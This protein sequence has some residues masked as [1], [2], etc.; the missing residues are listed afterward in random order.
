MKMTDPLN[1]RLLSHRE[2]L[3]DMT[4]YPMP[5]R[6]LDEGE[7]RLRLDL[8]SLTTNNI[9]YAGFGNSI[10]YWGCF[11]SPDPDYG[12]IPV[13]GFADIVEST[14]ED[15]PVGQ[16][17]W[18]YFPM[19]R[20][21]VVHPDE[22]TQRS[23]VDTSNG[24]DAIPAI[25]AR[26]VFCGTH[27]HYDATTEA[28][29]TIFRPLFMTSYGAVEFLRHHDF[30]NAGRI[31]VSGASS[32]TGMGIGW[33]LRRLGL[34]TIGLTSPRNMDFVTQGGLFQEVYTYDALADLG[35]GTKTV[36]VDLT[37][38]PK[39]RADLHAALGEDLAYD[40]FVGATQADE[41]PKAP[42]GSK[43]EPVFFFTATV[44]DSH[45]E[46]GIIHAFLDRYEDVQTQFVTEMTTGTTALLNIQE[47]QGLTGAKAVLRGLIKDGGDPSIGHVVRLSG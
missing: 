20:D 39:V 21:L 45:R 44:L 14:R 8:F 9:T 13:W 37:G 36:Y 31:V 2:N 18:G 43:I 42:T 22:V 30:F 34:T 11:P 35:R 46:R 1:D 27:N 24:R 29:S 28:A 16:R 10:G 7:V 4:V 25:Y 19:G 26:Y 40:C 41:F 3:L 47:T 15:V 23:F 5:D 17:V 33:C 38:S 32:K 6:A 12:A